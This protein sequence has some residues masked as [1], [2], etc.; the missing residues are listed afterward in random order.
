[1]G[2][3]VP[4]RKINMTQG[5][6]GRRGLAICLFRHCF[7]LFSFNFAHFA[8]FHHL[9]SSLRASS[10]ERAFRAN[11]Y[12]QQIRFARTLSALILNLKLNYTTHLAESSSSF[13]HRRLAEHARRCSQ[14][15]GTVWPAAKRVLAIRH[16]SLGNPACRAVFPSR[17]YL[18]HN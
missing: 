14:L 7:T 6:H 11:D 16:R 3:I 13:L 17:P 10:S 2:P 1:M 9:A 5:A 18:G 4:L 12:N 8:S 15:C